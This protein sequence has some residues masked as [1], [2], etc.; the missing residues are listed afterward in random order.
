MPEYIVTVR[1]TGHTTSV[2]LLPI[3]SMALLVT[4]PDGNVTELSHDSAQELI[5][6][7]MAR[8]DQYTVTV[9]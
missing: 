2:T 8:P 9:Q 6:F 5:V 1:S 3:I 7:V 4:M